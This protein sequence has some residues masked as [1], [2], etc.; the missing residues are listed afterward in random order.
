[1]TEQQQ[2]PDKLLN[3]VEDWT[4]P[5]K[6]SGIGRAK[7]IVHVTLLVA[8]AMAAIPT[9]GTVLPAVRNMYLA[10]KWKIPSEMVPDR[11]RQERLA[12]KNSL[13]PAEIEFV[14]Q[15]IDTATASMGYCKLSGDF[16]FFFFDPRNNR[17][18][19]RWISS[20]ELLGAYESLGW[21][22]W[23]VPSAQAGTAAKKSGTSKS[24]RVAQKAG[25]P[26]FKVMCQSLQPD[27]K[28]VRVVN[29]AGKCYRETKSLHETRTSEREEVACDTQCPT[30][31]KVE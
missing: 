1:M 19:E 13:C 9:I 31:E 2:D 5:P 15:Q 6:T 14:S 18:Y 30:P 29:R 10:A 26:V 23:I 25:A 28:I 22:D 3:A 4:K 20:N 27:S 16:Q 21:W 24:V 12:K 7:R 17:E 11:I 8:T